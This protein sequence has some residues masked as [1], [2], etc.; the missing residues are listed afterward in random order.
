MEIVVILP[1]SPSEVGAVSSPSPAIGYLLLLQRGIR[2]ET[3]GSLESTL[4]YF[5]DFRISQI[6]TF[7]HTKCV[8][9]SFVLF[10]IY[11]VIFFLF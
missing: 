1:I 8:I 2:L 5:R 3:P 9:S 6:L 7:L 11:T 4:L 10:G